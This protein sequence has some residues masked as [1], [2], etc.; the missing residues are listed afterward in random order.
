MSNPPHPTEHEQ[1][2]WEVKGERT[3]PHNRQPKPDR[4]GPALVGIVLVAL[5]VAVLL[6]LL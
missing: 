2:G 3:P 1:R 6:L 4:L 5:I